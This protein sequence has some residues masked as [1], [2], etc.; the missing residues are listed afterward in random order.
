MEV[1][2]LGVMTES[3]TATQHVSTG[4]TPNSWKS[5]FET[6]PGPDS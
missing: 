5:M 6:Y 4:I 2:L 3:D 1:K